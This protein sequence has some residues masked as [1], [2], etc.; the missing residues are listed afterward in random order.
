M[1]SKIGIEER[2]A[3][4]EQAP[5]GGQEAEEAANPGARA[6]AAKLAPACRIVPGDEMT[7]DVE[8]QRLRPE[9][10][11]EE[12]YAK[13]AGEQ[14]L[15]H[16]QHT[17]RAAHDCRDDTQS[18]RRGDDSAEHVEAAVAQEGDST[19]TQGDQQGD[20]QRVQV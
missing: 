4:G 10:G 8:D 2:I 12:D 16:E 6:L 9:Q 5:Y 15:A 17:R 19:L 1:E 14:G 3:K 11:E 18:K 20:Q 13:C 7:G